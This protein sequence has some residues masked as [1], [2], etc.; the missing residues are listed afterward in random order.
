MSSCPFCKA[1]LDAAAALAGKCPHCQSSLTSPPSG[2]GSSAEN[3][4]ATLD[5]GSFPPMPAKDT[6]S[7]SDVGKFGATLDS[8]Q[9]APIAPSEKPSGS[10]SEVNKFAATVDSKHFPPIP[11]EPEKPSGSD[12]DKFAATVDSKSFPAAQGAAPDKPSGSGS[13]ID[14]FGATIDSKSFPPGP[15][16][17]PEKPSGSGSDVNKFAATVDSNHFPPLLGE[18]KRE[19]GS[20][21]KFAATIDSHEF[22]P[23]APALPEKKSGEE[24]RFAAT[25]DSGSFP[26]T[27]AELEKKAREDSGVAKTLESG[28]VPETPSEGKGEKSGVAATL[29]SG[30][31]SF[32]GL[33]AGGTDSRRYAPTFDS[34][35]V[36]G[37]VQQRVSMM[38]SGKFASDATPRTSI[39]AES[40]SVESEANLVIQPR[41]LRNVKEAQGARADYE[42]VSRLGEGGMGVVMAARQSSIDRTVALKMLKPS[43]VKDPEARRKFLSE[44]VVTGDLEHP[45]IVPIYD[46]GKDEA[47]ALFYAMKRVKGT[48]WDTVIGTKSFAENLEILLKIADA[49]AF[50]H[51]RGVVHRDLKPENVM[52]GDFGE[53]LLMDWG[54]ALT[55]DSKKAGVGMAGTPAYMAPEMASGPI[56]RIGA[57]SDIYLLGA[58]LYEIIAGFPPHTGKNVLECL[59]AAARNEIRPTER[60]GE[61]VSIALKS[62][63]TKPEDRYASVVELKEAIQQYQSHS[64]SITLST[65]A[66]EEL[67][68]ARQRDEYEVYAR[69][70]FGFQEAYNLWNGNTRAKEGMAEAALA[71][72][73]SALRK[74]D[75]DLGASLL[76]P[77][78]PD[79]APVVQK[80][81]EAQRERDARQQRL[82][83]A[84][85]AGFALVGLVLTVVTVAFFWIRAEAENARKQEKIAVANAEE[86]DAQ[87]KI[88]KKNAKIAAENEQKATESARIAAENEQKAKE[89]EK[90]ATASAKI[91]AENE[92]KAKESEKKATES[93]KIAAENEKKAKESEQAAVDA[94]KREQR[95]A[96]IA[97]IGLAAAKIEENAFDSAAALLDECPVEL[98]NWEWGRLRYLCT[99]DTRTYNAQQPIESAVFS[100][101]G[102]KFATGGWGAEVRIWD[103]A[104]GKELQRFPAGGTYVFSLAFSPN[105][106]QL[107]IGVNDKPNYVKIWDVQAGKLTKSY[108][109]HGDAVVSVAFSRDGQRLLTSSYDQTARLYDLT[110]GQSTVFRRH[111]GWVWSARFSPDE[112]QVVTAGQDGSVIVWDA[113][114][115]AL[116]TFLGHVG[117]VY[118]AVF[119]PNG[120]QVASGGYDTRV[121][122]WD[123][124]EVA[125]FDM[126]SLVAKEKTAPKLAYRALEGHGAAVR[127][128]R[129]GQDGKT[130]VSGGN[131]NT[132]RV[133]DIADPK[134]LH[135]AKTVRGHGG[136]V[137]A[138]DIDPNTNRLLSA[139]H[140]RTAKLWDV[141]AY[142]EQRVMGTAM[143][144]GHT[145]EVLGADFAEKGLRIVSAGRDRTVRIWDPDSGKQLREY[146]EAR[147]LTE[148]HQFLISSAMYFPDGKQILTAAVDNTVRVWNIETGSELF[149]L[150]GTGLSAAV[151]LSRDGRWI[152]TGSESQAKKQAETATTTPMLWPAKLWDAKTGSLVRTFPGNLSEIT[153]VAISADNL[154]V[155]TGDARGRCRLWETATGKMLW[156][157]KEHSGNITA[158]VFLPSGDRVLTASADNTVAQ[159][160]VK[161]AKDNEPQEDRARILRHKDAVTSLS[162]SPD[163]R[164][165]LTVC[166][167]KAPKPRNDKVDPRKIPDKGAKDKTVQIWDVD[168]AKVLMQVPTGNAIISTAGFSPDGRRATTTSAD[169]IV[170]LWE[171]DPLREVK[172]PDGSPFL[173]SKGRKAAI[174]SAVF[175]PEGTSLLTIGGDE[176]DLWDM[177]TRATTKKFSRPGSVAAARFS[178]DGQRIAAGS[179]DSLIRIWNVEK[180]TVEKKLTGHV[181]FVNDVAFSRDGK[182]LVSAGGDHTA[183]VWDIATGQ[184]LKVLEGHT[185]PVRSAAFSRDGKLVVTASSDKTARIWDVGTGK[186]LMVLEKK[187]GQDGHD[188]AVRCA[189]FSNDGKWVLTGSDDK[190]AILWD[191]A[192]GTPKKLVHVAGPSAAPMEPGAA[193]AK[194][195]PAANEQSAALA[196]HTAGIN[197]VA[198]SPDDKRAITASQ[199]GTAKL[200]ETE[201]SKEI[202]TLKGHTQELTAA[203]FS[204]DGRSILT[205]SRDGS[206]I[207]W[208]SSKWEN[209]EP[210]KPS[211][212]AT[213]QAAPTMIGD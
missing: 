127:A 181:A 167:E 73:E 102:T 129:F 145:D 15:G 211:A 99:R 156:D 38:W 172:A 194:P 123:P 119:S 206:L 5:S 190:R 70:L 112:T 118:A 101:D 109:G 207:L 4:A 58:M 39:K 132:V 9:F 87:T 155:L 188:Q 210:G 60:T 180:H 157:V 144:E 143:L 115:K 149:S 124:N 133:W 57:A 19:S 8:N 46:V 43:A 153:A 23:A 81:R 61:L 120:K 125:P 184:C 147:E 56:D 208:L 7:G 89:S 71:Y 128:I 65:R 1:S 204:P 111:D 80:L 160:H 192:T 92:Q 165:V 11:A 76:D 28:S 32:A 59:F 45:N 183:R 202:I 174:W 114:G 50:A 14:K 201:T 142:L 2:E 161:K 162:L 148:G 97:R 173:T 63:E 93:A 51:S 72:A 48:P 164:R 40:Q 182:L 166:A 26:P 29:E 108:P 136:R 130:L 110:S 189:V 205:G 139:G 175:S 22:P 90:K 191:V 98:R 94:Q 179:W 66:E 105:G 75:F 150:P 17:E 41:V 54:L 213:V 137:T 195:N 199:D 34:G 18:G 36:P 47:G 154:Y 68:Q 103:S 24:H 95:E 200:W 3:F 113:H 116:H 122:L 55:E 126:K 31:V 138:C 52:L 171:L 106:R 78:N 121:L 44:A 69:S 151:A 85:R 77:K 117:P 146:H 96:Y 84:R 35:S 13:D 79:H 104:S 6:G 37:D 88:A 163:G 185:G 64:E 131:D 141:N 186:S 212:K 187:Q 169:G 170:Q 134:N 198:F 53:V 49:V 27:P 20:G 42:L 67:E 12:V 21:D 168:T 83:F 203:C 178:P 176:A 193:P 91:A 107:A 33:A 10:G 196:G 209:T 140:D 135:L 82:K 16:A 62:M 177:Q 86:A 197:A 158:A 74:G 159:W 30:S 100:P 25:L 152:V